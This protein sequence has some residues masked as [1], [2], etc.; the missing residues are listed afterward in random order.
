M[1]SNRLGCV[2]SLLISAAVTFVLLLLFGVFDANGAE[3]RQGA[4][5]TEVTVESYM[6]VVG[7]DG[8]SWTGRVNSTEPC[9][10][11]RKVTLFMKTSKG[12]KRIGVDTTNRE[13]RGGSESDWFIDAPE[14]KRATYFA[15]VKGSATCASDKSK[16]FKFP[17]DQPL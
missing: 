10:S 1:F 16:K 17:K 15:K 2:G 13:S 14:P 9:I 8:G 6:F 5:E 11:N 12:K 3:S 7:G 4:A